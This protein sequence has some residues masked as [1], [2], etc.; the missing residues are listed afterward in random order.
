MKT[1]LHYCA[2]KELLPLMDLPNVKIARAKQLFNAGY[3]N[4]Q[5]IAKA[6]PIEL[7]QKVKNLPQSQANKIIA[8]AKLQLREKYENLLD[9]A[10]DVLDN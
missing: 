1:R 2:S 3:C 8:C 10:A 6:D 5:S 9:A 7:Q 4:L